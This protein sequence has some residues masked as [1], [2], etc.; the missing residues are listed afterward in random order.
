[1]D[2]IYE[3]I[4]LGLMD[5]A[6]NSKVPKAMR[7]LIAILL[8][9]LFIIA[10]VSLVIYV[11]L[12]ED[13]GIFKRMFGGILLVAIAGYYIHLLMGMTKIRN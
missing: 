1:M 6:V 11:F 10:I 4:F 3:L 12:V 13:I 5:S 9:I 8:S 2:I 7:I